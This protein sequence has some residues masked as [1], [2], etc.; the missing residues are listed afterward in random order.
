MHYFAKSLSTYPY[1]VLRVRCNSCRRAGQYRIT[2][3]AVAFG[4]EATLG[5]VLAGVTGDCPFRVDRRKADP[6]N[7]C[8][9]YFPDLD[10]P[11]GP[12]DYPPAML[13]LKLVVGGKG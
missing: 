8:N 9:A 4:C 7:H 2:R 12:P 5:D 13:G 6:G 10:C 1:V 3:L 11:P